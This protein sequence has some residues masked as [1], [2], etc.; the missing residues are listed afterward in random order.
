M[1]TPSSERIRSYDKEEITKAMST[2]PVDIL[3]ACNS[4]LENILRQANEARSVSE[5][6]D[7]DLRFPS[8]VLVVLDTHLGMILNEPGVPAQELKSFWVQHFWEACLSTNF[9][10]TLLEYAGSSVFWALT[11]DERDSAFGCLCSF[12]HIWW[13]GTVLVEEGDVQV[14]TPPAT[15][16]ARIVT[17]SRVLWEMVWQHRAQ[18][19]ADSDAVISGSLTGPSRYGTLRY[20]QSLATSLVMIAST[21]GQGDDSAIRTLNSSKIAHV[22]LW[23]WW[24]LPFGDAQPDNHAL[25]ATFTVIQ[26]THDDLE[27][28]R[29]IDDVFVREIGADA[30]L[31]KLNRSL[32]ELPE[33][34]GDALSNSLYFMEVLSNANSALSVAYAKLPVS[35][36]VARALRKGRDPQ[37]SLPSGKQMWGERQLR[38]WGACSG[39]LV[40]IAEGLATGIRAPS[41]VNG[42]DIYSILVHGILVAIQVAKSGTPSL[43][44]K[45]EAAY[46][47]TFDRWTYN[48]RS[49]G[50]SDSGI[51]GKVIREL[52][53]AARTSGY[54]V[55]LEL[56]KTSFESNLP[57]LIVFLLDVWEQL[58]KALGVDE[59]EM[60]KG[61]TLHLPAKR[62]K[63][64]KDV[65]R[66]STVQRL[67]N[68][69]IGRSPTNA[70]AAASNDIAHNPNLF[71]PSR[72]HE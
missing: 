4:A 14:R 39:I 22:A 26:N 48:I 18:I 41:T 20:I 17:E 58:N 38:K 63:Y 33:I 49:R 28:Q 67:V 44:K 53:D 52:S 62:C 50:R 66:P 10:C 40:N 3:K 16:V 2:A 11:S 37:T 43:L 30:V 72:L 12:V 19:M 24:V 60:R 31:T 27:R 71:M 5:L 70:N 9:P 68:L 57:D 36:S 45:Y 69:V 47:D 32:N 46:S 34:A 56:R 35:A 59:E 42:A 7:A 51:P 61:I 65:D 23:T 29:F 55:L 15:W 54:S 13:H 25:E 1:S 6:S 64:A 21:Q 8:S